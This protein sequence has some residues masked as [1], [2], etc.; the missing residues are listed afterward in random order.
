LPVHL[1]SLMASQGLAW[2][3]NKP[4]CPTEIQDGLQRLLATAQKLT[5]RLLEYEQIHAQFLQLTGRE[6]QVLNLVLDGTANREAAEKLCISVRTVES[7]RAK[8]YSKLG[9]EN[10]VELVRKYDRLQHLHSR[11][12]CAEDNPLLASNPQHELH[13]HLSRQTPHRRNETANLRAQRRSEQD[14]KV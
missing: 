14:V 13:N 11:F 9:I 6:R 1:V 10:L 8:V 7:R 4:L 12:S 2:A 5:D 3:F